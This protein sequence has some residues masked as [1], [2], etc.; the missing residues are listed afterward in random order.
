MEATFTIQERQ[1]A[2]QLTFIFVFAFRIKYGAQ[3]VCTI[4]GKFS[5]SR[6]LRA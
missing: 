5:P 2:Y 3:K 6:S 1:R 4:S